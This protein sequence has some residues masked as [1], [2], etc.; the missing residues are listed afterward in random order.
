M[1]ILH[2][3]TEKLKIVIRHTGNTAQEKLNAHITPIVSAH[4]SRA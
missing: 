1:N 3:P 2:R 4:F